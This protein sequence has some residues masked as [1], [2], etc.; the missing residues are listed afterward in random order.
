VRRAVTHAAKREAPTRQASGRAST[1]DEYLAALELRQRAALQRLRRII[2]AAVPK[3]EECISYQMPAFRLNGRMLAW[4]G[5][6]THHCS[7]F[8]GAYPIAA[9]RADLKN[10]DT[11]RGTVR[12]APDRPLPAALVRKL[13]NARVAETAR[14]HARRQTRA[15]GR[16]GR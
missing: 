1:P 4:Y 7:F 13:V 2:R 14:R 16:R 10:Y 3:A 8:P 9:C 6:A 5:A 11:S 12:F 15:A